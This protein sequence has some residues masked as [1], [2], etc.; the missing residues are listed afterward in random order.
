MSSPATPGE[1]PPKPEHDASEWWGIAADNHYA[2]GATPPAEYEPTAST[3]NG[4]VPSAPPET[5]SPAWT[6][7]PARSEAAYGFP[8][9]PPAARHET[10]Y[11]H[12]GRKIIAAGIIAVAALTGAI[13]AGAEGAFSSSHK[14]VAKQLPTARI[15]NSNGVDIL[16][17]PTQGEP[18]N[19]GGPA[20]KAPSVTAS[21]STSES[22]L[23]AT[24]LAEKPEGAPS[25]AEMDAM[26]INT[27]EDLGQ[28]IRLWYVVDKMQEAGEYSPITASINN[29]AQ[30]IINDS[31]SQALEFAYAAVDK[32][33]GAKLLSGAYFSSESQAYPA[34][35][36]AVLDNARDPHTPLN[37]VYG[38][39]T[40]VRRGM[41][42]N[43][44]VGYTAPYADV[45]YTVTTDAQG[46]HSYTDRFFFVALDNKQE[47][48]YGG[49]WLR[50][51]PTTSYGSQ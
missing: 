47:Q 48:P 28:Q 20:T 44:T 21:L 43:T 36:T 11:S 7:P 51:N 37:G 41:Y 5:P 12:R 34:D 9:I 46:E 1:Q 23:S 3:N 6:A 2:N 40:V 27:F 10:S 16:L 29:S 8:P 24:I 31:Y 25:I 35:K 45:S 15:S 32:D 49:M 14:T 13:V 22:E 17:P 19:S 26:P 42:T 18:T 50:G 30:G 38:N 4:P 33:T 39:A